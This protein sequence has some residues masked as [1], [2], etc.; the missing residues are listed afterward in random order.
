VV[1]RQEPEA[2]GTVLYGQGIT[3]YISGESAVMPPLLTMTVDE[4]RT[5]LIEKGFKLGSVTEK[6]SD[7]KEGTVIAQSI[8]GGA[9]ALLDTAVG[10]TISQVRVATYRA[11]EDIEIDVPFDD[12]QIVATIEDGDGE[13]RE[14]YSARRDKGKQTIHLYLDSVNPGQHTLSVYIEGVLETE[15]E[16]N[17]E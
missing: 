17:F 1:I 5:A 4:A 6:L 2:G 15:K 16:V 13:A 7:A 11:S 14:V 12:C 3:L 9:V 8:D 10:I